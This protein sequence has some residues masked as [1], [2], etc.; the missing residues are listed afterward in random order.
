MVGGLIMERPAPG[1]Q[2]PLDCSSPFALQLAASKTQPS[3]RPQQQLASLAPIW[4]TPRPSQGTSFQSS[5][6]V[7]NASGSSENEGSPSPPTF[8]LPPDGSEF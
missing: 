5:E 2:L 8:G 1:L 4:C 6:S 3:R 7:S